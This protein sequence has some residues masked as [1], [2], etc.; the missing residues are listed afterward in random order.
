MIELV[1]IVKPM[2]YIPA[3][4]D[5][6]DWSGRYPAPRLIRDIRTKYKRDLWHNSRPKRLASLLGDFWSEEQEAWLK[7]GQSPWNYE[8]T[9][10]FMVDAART[11]NREEACRRV[12]RVQWC[13]Y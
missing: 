6:S 9:R 5:G 7:L 4:D 3:L 11:Q 13:Q 8:A 1:P 12:E 2:E 10:T